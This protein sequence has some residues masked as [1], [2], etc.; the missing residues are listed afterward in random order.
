MD[1]VMKTR[2]GQRLFTPPHTS[3]YPSSQV[4]G[5]SRRKGQWR[6]RK[7]ATSAPPADARAAPLPVVAF[8]P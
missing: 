4:S 5:R 3:L 6:I 2:R 1:T 8:Y 7:H